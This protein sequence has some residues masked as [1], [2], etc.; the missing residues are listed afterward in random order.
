[1]SFTA[2]PAQDFIP[3]RE[4]FVMVDKLIYADEKIYRSTLTI[5]E[6]NI[7]AAE[8]VFSSAGMVEAMAQT[9]AAGTGYFYQ[10]RG[11]PAPV[12]YIG[13]VQH[14]EILDWPGLRQEIVIEIELQ[15]RV[16]QV[17]LVSGTVKM[18][19]RLM[20]RCELKIFISNHS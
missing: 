3:Q 16:L 7:F 6:E 11:E 17:S 1:M 20:A 18:N 15:T 12:G 14:L 5:R 19:D 8:G 2:V 10:M 13:A 9:A 4:P